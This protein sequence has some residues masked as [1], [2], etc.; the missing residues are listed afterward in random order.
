MDKLTGLGL[1]TLGLCLVGPPESPGQ[2]SA[3]PVLES[4]AE[5][6]ESLETLQAEMTQVKTYPQ[7]GLSDPPERG[8]FYVKR[9]NGDTRVRIEIVEP[10]KRIVTVTKGQYVLYQP[11]INQAI[12]GTV[13]AGQSGGASFIRYFFGNLGDAREDYEI[14]SVGQEDVEGR[15]TEHLHLTAKPAGAGY[16]REI[17]LWIDTEL[18]VPVRQRFVEPN[19]SVIEL[20]FDDI[21]INAKINDSLFKIDLPPDVERVRG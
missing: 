16:Y 15:H 20:S 14:S 10:Q 5:A 12:E 11:K 21:R 4:M 6:Y 9:E 1:A 18:W 17:D 19:Q 7:L 13:R 2:S 8:R 3:E